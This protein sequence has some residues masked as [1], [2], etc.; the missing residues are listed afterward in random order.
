MRCAASYI[1]D[2]NPMGDVAAC[3]TKYTKLLVL[4]RAKD[5]LDCLMGGL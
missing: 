2:K 1:H 5:L 3:A 4:E